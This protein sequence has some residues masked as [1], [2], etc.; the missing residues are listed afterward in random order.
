M[1]R[2]RQLAPFLLFLFLQPQGQIALRAQVDRTGITGTVTDQQGNRVPQSS[3]RA[4]ETGTGFQRE[5]STT[6]QGTYELSGLPPGVYSVQFLK[7]GFSAFTAENVKQL[8]GQTRTLNIRLE[9]A[10]GSQQTT[11]TEPLVQ[12]DKVDATVGAAIEREQLSDLPINGRN[13]AT[14]TALAP[15]AID[16]GAGDQRTIRFAGHG[17]DDNNLNICA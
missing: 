17:L 4:T 12:L 5:T 1:K 13:W 9:L 7:T 16:N 2:S 6:S 10:Q 11:V 14:L 15:G 8:V 3:V